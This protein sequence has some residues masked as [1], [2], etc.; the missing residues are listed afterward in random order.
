MPGVMSVVVMV[1]GLEF[2][3]RFVAL[4]L[5]R[6]LPRGP[7]VAFT[8]AVRTNRQDRQLYL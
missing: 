8:G 1:I 5:L 4:G 2:G 7:E 6:S 3:E